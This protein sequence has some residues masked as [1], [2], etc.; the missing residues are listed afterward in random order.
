M[1]SHSLW[2]T[3]RIVIADT[4]RDS[5]NSSGSSAGKKSCGPEP[6]AVLNESHANVAAG[7]R[8][9]HLSIAANIKIAAL[10]EEDIR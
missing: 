8:D 6:S 7:R 10:V 4:N 2:L 9:S 5:C 1:V 3:H